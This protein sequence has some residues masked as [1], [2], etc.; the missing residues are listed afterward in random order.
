M[1]LVQQIRQWNAKRRTRNILLE[2]SEAQL[3]DIGV[4][5]DG[6]YRQSSDYQGSTQY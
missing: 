5:R 2:M 4:T 3:R 6:C 1:K